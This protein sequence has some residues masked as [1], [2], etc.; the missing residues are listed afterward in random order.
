MNDTRKTSEPIY[1]TL[2]ED[3][4][5]GPIVEMF[6]EEMPGRIAGL[7]AWLE[8]GNK[9]ELRR[10]A[11]QL[12]GAAGSYGFQPITPAAARLEET[13]RQGSSEE[14]IHRAVGELVDLCRRAAAGRP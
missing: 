4:D 12:K 3:P 13:I 9:E 7:L 11:H 2:A 5:L 10:A 8:S 6:V 14:E 1:S